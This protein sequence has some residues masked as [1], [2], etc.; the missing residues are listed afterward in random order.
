MRKYLASRG[1]PLL[2]TAIVMAA[3]PGHSATAAG[4][5]PNSSSGPQTF[6]PAP[7]LLYPVN[8]VLNN[9]NPPVF[10]W[11]G[12][13]NAQSY[14]LQVATDPG[15][16]NTVASTT[17]GNTRYT[18]T[19]GFGNGTY[20]WRVLAQG[21][22][23]QQSLLVS[24]AFSVNWRGAPTPLQPAN[25]ARLQWGRDSFVFIWGPQQF[26]AGF[27][28]QIATSKLFQAP[29]VSLST[30]NRAALVPGDTLKNGV[31]YYW[32]VQAVDA[33]KNL[34]YWSAVYSFTKDWHPTP[35]LQFPQPYVPSTFPNVFDPVLQ[36]SRINGAVKYQVQIST[37]IEL[38]TGNSAFNSTPPPGSIA[39]DETT[40]LPVLVPKLGGLADAT[41]FWHVR[42][43]DD[44]GNPGP[45]SYWMPRGLGPFRLT[46]T[47]PAPVMPRTP[48]DGET[49]TIPRLTWQAVPFASTYEVQ[50]STDQDFAKT[51]TVSF[52][53]YTNEL[54]P[55]LW[56][57]VPAFNV[58]YYW[59]VRAIT[60]S[61]LVG[62]WSTEL[63]GRPWSFIFSS[64]G[65]VAPIEPLNYQKILVPVLRWSRLPNADHYE[66]DIHDNVT[67]GFTAFTTQ[68]TTFTPSDPT[69]LNDCAQSGCY[70]YV[71]GVLADKN[72]EPTPDQTNIGAFQNAP[73]TSL[74]LYKVPVPLRPLPGDLPSPEMPSFCWGSTSGAQNYQIFY[75]SGA[76]TFQPLTDKTSATCQT[77]PTELPDGTYQWFVRV[78]STSGG[79]LADGPISQLSI[80]SGLLSTGSTSGCGLLASDYLSPQV[81]KVNLYQPEI[82]WNSVPCAHSYHLYVATDPFFTNLVDEQIS[83][84]YTVFLPKVPYYPANATVY[85]LIRPEV[86]YQA[87]G[88]PVERPP[89]AQGLFNGIKLSLTVPLVNLSAPASNAT[90]SETPLFIWSRFIGGSAYE[91][92]VG[93]QP[94]LSGTPVIDANTFSSSYAPTTDLPDGVYYWRV[95]PVNAASQKLPFSPI[96]RFVKRSQ[97]PALFGPADNSQIT[98]MPV[99]T[100]QQLQRA[101]QYEIQVDA[102]DP[103]FQGPLVDTK[104]VNVGAWAPTIIYPSNTRF[105][106]YYWRVRAIDGGGNV[107]PFSAAR[108]F[109]LSLPYPLL[110][111]PQRGQI[112]TTRF[113]VLAWQPLP[114]AATYNLEVSTSP[115]FPNPQASADIAAAGTTLVSTEGTA[116]TPEHAQIP[117]GTY[118]WRVLPVDGSG[119]VGL[120][121]IARTFTVPT[122]TITAAFLTTPTGLRTATFPT[123]TKA[124]QIR[125]S[126]QYADPANDTFQLILYNSKGQ[127]VTQSVPN[128]F[129]MAKGTELFSYENTLNGNAIPLPA[130]K[131]R[132]DL[133]INTKVNTSLFFTVK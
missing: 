129:G 121:S 114:G 124:V 13:P 52:T 69:L 32:R 16:S 58:R 57:P 36:W 43:I 103:T 112:L 113:P 30:P 7:H 74:T 75:S 128:K 27:N 65:P 60:G 133:V 126:W 59:R 99:F 11:T 49:I 97:A 34:G 21:S 131:Y 91:I 81:Q 2:V 66:V 78:F 125:L 31:V 70:W 62:K 23:N 14:S 50:Q 71:R 111:A 98:A 123:G 44:Q 68:N 117:L 72:T 26:A 120:P 110:V 96:W 100:W 63:T 37:D 25:G 82:S 94:D 1:A 39:D 48:A 64:G 77:P 3:L 132:L 38:A 118:Y 108:R 115:D 41:Y 89:R 116:F 93:S 67:N 8:K 6:L 5:T 29:I 80:D 106:Y 53:S 12:V 85:V 22:A 122:V 119:N 4:S 47:P 42:G 24:A 101:V 92:Q 88:T 90:V 109:H 40:A 55:G 95:R 35:T 9:P 83:Y 54:A 105:A 17:T 87:D 104:K 18:P 33:A 15:F 46:V 84:P 28:L 79:I 76:S 86:G 51:N 107:G 19:K 73:T 127:Q 130:G 10:H 102:N 20:Y 45:W 56:S 61:G